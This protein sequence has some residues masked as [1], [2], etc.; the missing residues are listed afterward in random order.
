MTHYPRME[1]FAGKRMAPLFGKDEEISTPV[2]KKTT[3]KPAAKK[4]A[5]AK[6][7]V[8]KKTSKK[9]TKKK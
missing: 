9:I 4:K 5:P 1:G 3:R 8:A 2:K 6:K 7:I